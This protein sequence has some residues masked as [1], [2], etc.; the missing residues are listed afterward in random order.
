MLQGFTYPFGADLCWLVVMTEVIFCYGCAYVV[1]EARR[2]TR[3]W[4]G[5]RLPRWVLL[6]LLAAY[7]AYP[8]T[9]SVH[10]LFEPHSVFLGVFADL[11]AIGLAHVAALIPFV[12]FFTAS[13]L[14]VAVRAARLAT[15]R[16][17]LPRYTYP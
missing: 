9:H 2:W 7:A 15:K 16:S 17:R 10:I 6:L 3:I 8:V 11:A 14:F 13:R 1:S 5:R 4:V 12:L